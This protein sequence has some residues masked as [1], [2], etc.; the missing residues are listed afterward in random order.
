MVVQRARLADLGWIRELAAQCSQPSPYR[1]G[2]AV[3]ATRD[4]LA[5]LET[6]RLQPHLKLLV[7][8]DREGFALVHL[9]GIEDAS[10]QPQAEL[11]EL[12][13]RSDEALEALIDEAARMAYKRGLKCLAWRLPALSELERAE[14]LG[15]RVERCEILMLCDEKGPVKAWPTDPALERLREDA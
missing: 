14:G 2:D 13:A 3:R 6:T 15:F 8:G 12:C 4:R 7:A 1:A 5:H 10:G 9:A 11:L